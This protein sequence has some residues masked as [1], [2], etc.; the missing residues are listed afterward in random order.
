MYESTR[1]FV[2]GKNAKRVDISHL[3]FHRLG[4]W[5]PRCIF[6]DRSLVR[7]VVWNGQKDVLGIL[8]PIKDRKGNR[9]DLIITGSIPGYPS[10]FFLQG[11]LLVALLG[12][13][14]P[15]PDATLM[16]PS[17]LVLLPMFLSSV[18]LLVHISGIDPFRWVGVRG[19]WEFRRLSVFCIL[20]VSRFG[21]SHH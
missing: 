14:A 3:L 11:L 16:L 2:L 18:C 17:T 1:N 12:C 13:R 7:S 6:G 21:V 20:L 10:G 5:S 9:P 4:L 15:R 8:F 19:I